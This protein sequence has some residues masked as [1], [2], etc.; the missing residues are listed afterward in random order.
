[1]ST[2]KKAQA[3]PEEKAEA[4]VYLGPSIDKVVNHGTVFEGGIL[5]AALQQKAAE[6][7]AIRG[8]IVPTSRYAE[9]ARD[10]KLPEGR[11]RILY[12]TVSKA[13]Q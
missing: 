7:P 2:K 1:M 13:V 5:T 8:L 4:M 3:S 11:Y 12:D 9:V 10:V 6:I